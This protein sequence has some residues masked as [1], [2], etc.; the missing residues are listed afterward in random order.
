[1][2]VLKDEHLA[3][4]RIQATITRLTMDAASLFLSRF[5]QAGEPLSKARATALF[6]H[7]RGSTPENTSTLCRKFLLPELT[8]IAPQAPGNSWYPHP[9]YSDR[10]ANEPDISTAYRLISGLLSALSELGFPPSAIVL[11]GFSQGACLVLDYASRH[12]RRYGGIIGFS[13]SIIGSQICSVGDRE[14]LAG[15]PVFLSGSDADPYVPV[16]RIEAT[17]RLMQ[18]LGGCLQKHIYRD[19][20]HVI[21]SDEILKAHSLIGHVISSAGSRL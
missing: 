12:P 2:A 9:F 4:R 1:M 7:G 14:S 6:F 11:M 17:A 20:R 13:G 5:H 10:S 3:A 21:N 15:T 19:S 8:V 18:T 16:E